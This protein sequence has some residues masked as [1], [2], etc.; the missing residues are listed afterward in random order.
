MHFLHCAAHQSDAQELV[1]QLDK[2]SR[3][4]V[5][6]FVEEIDACSATSTLFS[7]CLEVANSIWSG[8]QT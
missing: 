8:S 3:V 6:A 1:Y 2:M 4:E 7:N 5:V